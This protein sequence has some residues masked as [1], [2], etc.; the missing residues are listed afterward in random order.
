MKHFSN[1]PKEHEQ[2]TY[3][4]VFSRTL[5]S[6][7]TTN[8]L[9]QTE[10]PITHSTNT[11]NDA[12]HDVTT[13][14]FSFE[15]FTN[16]LG[17]YFE[18][19]SPVRLFNDEWHIIF[20]MNLTTM[21]DEFSNIQKIVTKVSD[22]CTLLE[23]K[24]KI[25]DTE[26]DSRH[27]SRGCS[28]VISQIQLL[29]ND[30][31][32]FHVDWFL[33]KLN[34]RPKRG[35]FNIVG[36]ILNS[37]FGT[38]AQED[39]KEYLARFNE[40][41][42][43]DEHTKVI[44][45]EQTTLIKSTAQILDKMNNDNIL[46]QQQL[47]NQ[48]NSIEV[49]MN[50]LRYNFEKLWMNLEV[51]SQMDDLLLFTVLT[52]NS[53]HDKQKQFL[54]ALALGNNPRSQTPIILPPALLIRELA[55]IQN[56][57]TGRN[58]DLPLTVDKDTIQYFYQITTTRTRIIDD[59]LIISMS[60]PLVGLQEYELLKLTSFPQTLKNGLYSFIIPDHEY[61]A[62]DSFR[63]TFITFSNKELENCHDLRYR[64]TTP[65]LIC[66]QSSPVMQTSSGRD[67]CGIT[68]LSPTPKDNKCNIRVTNIT[69]EIFLKL[70]QPNSWIYNFP[71]QQVVYIRCSNLPTMEKIIQGT[72]ILKIKQDC[73]IKTNNILIQGHTVFNSEVYPE[74]RP[75]VTPDFK[76]NL[77]NIMPHANENFVIK[78]MDS[79]TVISS[80]E[81]EKLKQ[82]STSIDELQKLQRTRY[83]T[84]PKQSTNWYTIVF[85][86]LSGLSIIIMATFFSLQLYYIL[87]QQSDTD[88]NT[89]SQSIYNR[90]THTQTVV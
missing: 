42:E 73:Q 47:Q 18:K 24:Y 7:S 75:T 72:G 4:I 38:L 69:S 34:N 86:I 40:M 33:G 36:T 13:D 1:L 78:R 76:I 2:E 19:I 21:Q 53:F 31:E 79:P 9:N 58:L 41:K 6:L 37:F 5:L 22:I 81:S 25:N 52:L 59:Q 83:Q 70:R 12:Q 50:K 90:P 84:T 56:H 48:F 88:S 71:Q 28:S 61:I 66:M 14:K 82:L 45:D 29:K 67:D 60:I 51:Q 32:D 54:E 65:E 87:H 46:M 11:T 89:H 35:A 27:F 49:E 20:H 16:S 77:T 39:A 63:E 85:W 10:H 8:G 17:I 43:N 26:H 30:I 15:P 57:I 3:K 68:L 62:I 44:L 80:G 23:T 64:S 74:I 55:N